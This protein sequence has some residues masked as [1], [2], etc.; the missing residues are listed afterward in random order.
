MKY[1][2][3]PTAASSASTMLIRAA[4]RLLDVV[5]HLAR[6]EDHAQ[7]RDDEA[8]RRPPRLGLSPVAMPTITG[9]ATPVALIGATIDIVPIA[10]AR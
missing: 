7:R 8:R 4:R 6:G 2:P 9:S 3:K 1:V 5:V 10:S